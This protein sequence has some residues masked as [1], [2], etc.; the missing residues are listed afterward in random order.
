MRTRM[1]WKAA[2]LAL[3]LS[4]LLPEI[5]LAEYRTVG[6]I[7]GRTWHVTATSSYD[8]ITTTS[9]QK[10]WI[11]VDERAWGSSPNPKKDER[12]SENHWAYGSGQVLISDIYGELGAAYTSQHASQVY[13]GGATTYFY[14][15]EPLGCYSSFCWWY[16]GYG[17][18]C[19]Y[20]C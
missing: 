14:T 17:G 5:A 19:G 7:A 8:A 6:D 1:L 12:W 9:S 4:L 18:G 20:T 16:S 3:A 10:Y 13:P 15:S 2:L 11:Y